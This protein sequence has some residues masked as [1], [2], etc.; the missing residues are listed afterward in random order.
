MHDGRKVKLDVSFQEPRCPFQTLTLHTC[1]PTLLPV[2][3][4]AVLVV[5]QLGQSREVES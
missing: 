3:L 5:H 4:R 2:G 1:A